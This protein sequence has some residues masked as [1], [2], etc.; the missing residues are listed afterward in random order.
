MGKMSA[1]VQEY[2]VIINQVQVQSEL[3]SIF[4][5]CFALQVWTVSQVTILA[6]NL[7]KVSYYACD[8]EA[9]VYCYSSC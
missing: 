6:R 2:S 3:R 9:L 7:S 4:M 1:S 8:N 5:L